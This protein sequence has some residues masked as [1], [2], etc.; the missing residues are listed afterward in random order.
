MF[1]FVSE[2]VLYGIVMNLARRANFT[3]SLISTGICVILAR[4]RTG[5]KIQGRALPQTCGWTIRCYRILFASTYIAIPSPLPRASSVPAVIS[6]IEVNEIPPGHYFNE[7]LSVSDWVTI[8][9]KY[10]VC[11]SFYSW[12]LRISAS[13]VTSRFM[14]SRIVLVCKCL[15]YWLTTPIS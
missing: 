14:P 5:L 9:Q 6:I 10:T 15:S 8:W 2:L 13:D 12:S 7:K 1:R 4:N 11:L 3:F